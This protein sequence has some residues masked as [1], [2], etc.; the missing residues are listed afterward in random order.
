VVPTSGN[1]GQTWG[2]RG[3]GEQEGKLI[4]AERAREHCVPL[5]M[6]RKLLAAAR[7]G[8]GEHGILR[9]AN[10]ALLRMTTLRLLR[11]RLGGLKCADRPDVHRVSKLTVARASIFKIR[12][13]LGIYVLGRWPTLLGVDSCLS[14]LGEGAQSLRFLQGRVRCSLNV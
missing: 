1:F 12:K 7:E 5:R 4:T 13:K 3:C 10:N 6:G 11:C 2:T 8:I 9:R 14:H